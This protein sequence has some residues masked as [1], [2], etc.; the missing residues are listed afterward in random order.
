MLTFLYSLG[1]AFGGVVLA[2]VWAEEVE[3]RRRRTPITGVAAD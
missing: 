2:Y 1:A 3:L